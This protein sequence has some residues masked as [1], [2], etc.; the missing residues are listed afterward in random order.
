MNT[1]GKIVRVELAYEDGS[2]QT[3]TG[4]PAEAWLE[5]VNNVL[6]FAQIRSGQPAIGT[7]PWKWSTTDD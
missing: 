1:H 5:D 4:P 2:V 3:L 7:F 6:A